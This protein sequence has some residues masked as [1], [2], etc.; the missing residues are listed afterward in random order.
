MNMGIA[1]GYA[2]GHAIV[3]GELEAYAQQRHALAKQWV[4]LNKKIT[5]TVTNQHL[6]AKLLRSLLFATLELIGKYKADAIG[7]SLFTKMLGVKL[8]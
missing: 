1:D 6:W 3:R 8:N 7:K 5:T 4:D 2:L